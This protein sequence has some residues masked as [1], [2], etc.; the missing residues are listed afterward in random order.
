VPSAASGTSPL[1]H[2]PRAAAGMAGCWRRLSTIHASCPPRSDLW[3]FAVFLLVCAT[4]SAQRK[5]NAMAATR[6]SLE[7]PHC[8]AANA[9][10]SGRPLA[11]R[12]CPFCA[13]R[14]STDLQISCFTT[15][16]LAPAAPPT[17]IRTAVPSSNGEVSSVWA[18]S[19]YFFADLSL[20]V[21]IIL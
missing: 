5:V 20:T 4:R 8:G 16:A 1:T 10:W 12:R 19:R 15:K 14:Y 9:H 3:K 6:V 13:R 7:P 17:I 11:S 21:C 2:A 18:D